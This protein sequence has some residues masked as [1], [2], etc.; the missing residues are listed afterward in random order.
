MRHLGSIVLSLVV[1]A[2]LYVL[3]GL[4]TVKVFSTTESGGHLGTTAVGVLALIAAG[5]LYT[6]LMLPRWSPL[7]L[8]LAGLVLLVIQGW[9]LFASTNF[10]QTLSAKVLGT[11]AVLYAPARFGLPLILAMPLLLTIVSPRRWRRSAQP[12]APVQYPPAA[13]PY[14][15]QPYAPSYPPAP[16]GPSYPAAPAPS[17]VPPVPVPAAEDGSS[18]TRPLY[19]PPSSFPPPPPAPGWGQPAA[20]QPPQYAAPQSAPP[21]PPQSAP[22]APPAWPLAERPAT[23]G[24]EPTA[25]VTEPPADPDSTRKL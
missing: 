15:Y 4:G 21:A 11:D 24:D 19:P 13:Q 5:L 20:P 25:L 3:A 7:G 18:A 1:T 16:P 2:L 9:D 22:P 23:P 10:V 14:G 8:V 17:S 12:A 6:L